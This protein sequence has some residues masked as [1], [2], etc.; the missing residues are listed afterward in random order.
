MIIHSSI[1]RQSCDTAREREQACLSK[2]IE[3]FGN[4]EGNQ[5]GKTE[6]KR[7]LGE[8]ITFDSHFSAI[9]HFFPLLI[10]AKVKFVKN[11]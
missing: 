10:L 1:H 8:N 9:C 2:V 3:G 4:R 5:R 7:K 11:K 6:K